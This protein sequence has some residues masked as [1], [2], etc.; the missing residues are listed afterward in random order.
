MLINTVDVDVLREYEKLHVKTC[1]IR[2]ISMKGLSNQILYAV[3]V[4]AAIDLV[5]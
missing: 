4:E 3:A 2:K 1:K 5:S